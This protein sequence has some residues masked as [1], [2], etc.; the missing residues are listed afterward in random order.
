MADAHVEELKH[1]LKEH[2][3]G[4]TYP[5]DPPWVARKRM[6]MDALEHCV[7]NNKRPR[8]SFPKDVLWVMNTHD[9]PSPLL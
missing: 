2:S 1:G 5:V 4:R 3:D 9:D 7:G 6:R 8:P